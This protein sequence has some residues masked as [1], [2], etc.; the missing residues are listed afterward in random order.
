M[1]FY[2]RDLQKGDL[3]AISERNKFVLAY[4]FG[5]GQGDSLQYYAINRTTHVID[6]LELN[7]LSRRRRLY[8]EYIN[9]VRSNRVLLYDISFITDIDEKE[10]II[11]V[12]AYL[13]NNGYLN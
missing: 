13:Q 8:K 11:K 2:G 10:K 7:P 3:I 12:G 1:E 5:R 6:Y 4:Y 9:A